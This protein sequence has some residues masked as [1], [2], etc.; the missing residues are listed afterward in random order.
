MAGD[1]DGLAFL[2]PQGHRR[3]HRVAVAAGVARVQ[4]FHGPEVDFAAL[5]DQPE[6]VVQTQIRGGGGGQAF[7]DE[8]VDRVVFLPQ[9]PGMVGVGATP[10]MPKSRVCFRAR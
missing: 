10:L 7:V 8:G 2:V 5:E 9:N 6:Q 4:K 3:G 1:Q